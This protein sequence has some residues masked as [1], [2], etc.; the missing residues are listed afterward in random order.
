VATEQALTHAL[1]VLIERLL[2]RPERRGREPRTLRLGARLVGGGSWHCEVALREPTADRTRL[3]LALDAKL[4][5]LPAPAEEL[6][7]ELGDLAPGNRQEPL[8][9]TSGAARRTRL[10]GAVRQ[11]RAAVGETAA[12]RVV[13]VDAESRLPERRFGLVPR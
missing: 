7:V 11:L 1:R 4:R 2:A 13:E 12:L 6:A 9:R 3:A 8:F 10:D 5:L